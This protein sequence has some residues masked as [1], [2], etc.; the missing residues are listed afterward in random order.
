MPTLELA[1]SISFENIVVATDFSPA[2]VRAVECATAIA[3]DNHAQLFVLNAA[4]SSP[5]LPIPLDPSPGSLDRELIEA[6]NRLATLVSSEYFLDLEHEEI[7]ER[8]PVWDVVED[9]L[10]QKRA[11]LLVVGTHGRTGIKKLVLGSVA[12]E[13]FRRSACPVLTIGPLAAPVKQIRRVLFATD[14]GHSSVHALPYAIDFANRKEG[15]LILLHLTPPTPI[16]YVGPAWY[17][18]TDFVNGEEM[19]KQAIMPK[20]RS[21]LPS[22]D[23]L[24]CNVNYMVDVHYPAEGIVSIAKQYN[25]DLIVMGVRESGRSAAHVAAHMPWAVA[26]EVVCNAECPVLTVRG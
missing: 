16:E 22:A 11:D 25:V 17:P 2:S 20:L 1:K 21:L 7:A 24:N 8:G 10:K 13:I 4:P 23:G 15:E 5:H 12:E 9:V 26:Y 6:K 3:G 18:S 19:D 14:F